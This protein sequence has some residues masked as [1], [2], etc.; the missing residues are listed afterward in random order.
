MPPAVLPSDVQK[1]FDLR[2]RQVLTGSQIGVRRPPGRD[3]SFYNGWRDQ[4]QVCFRHAF[5]PYS[6]NDCSDNEPSLDSLRMKTAEN[7]E[8]F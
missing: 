3:C 8:L 1:P 5:G 7:A 6:P 2:F 4:L